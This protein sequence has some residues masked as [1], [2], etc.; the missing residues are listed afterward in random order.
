MPRFHL[1]AFRAGIMI[2]DSFRQYLPVSVRDHETVVGGRGAPWRRENFSRAGRRDVLGS[3]AAHVRCNAGMVLGR[4][5]CADA[6]D[7]V[8]M[9]VA[10]R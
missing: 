1:E 3:A 5:G 6:G 7:G 8:R 9:G 10:V 2:V 4:T